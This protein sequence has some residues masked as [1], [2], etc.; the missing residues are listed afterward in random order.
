VG[1]FMR[2]RA[3]QILAQFPWTQAGTRSAV[4]GV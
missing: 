1:H 3:L 4:K 2:D